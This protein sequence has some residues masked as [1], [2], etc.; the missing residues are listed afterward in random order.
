MGPPWTIVT[1][2]WGP[3]PSGINTNP[4]ISIPPGA[5]TVKAQGASSVAFEPMFV[6]RWT[7]WTR[8]PCAARVRSISL[9]IPY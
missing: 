8:L 5:M 4:W 2:G 1:R 7:R 3:G 9:R 6:I